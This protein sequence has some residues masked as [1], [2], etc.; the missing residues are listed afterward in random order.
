MNILTRQISIK[1]DNNDV[2]FIGYLRDGELSGDWYASAVG[3]VGGFQA[4]KTQVPPIPSGY[5]LIG[6]VTGHYKGKLTNTNPGSNLPER[7][8]VSLVTTQETTT[9]PPE[10]KISGNMR[11]YLGEFGS[12]EYVETKFTSVQFNFYSRYL[13]AKT[14]EY[15]ITL[16][17]ELSLD[18]VFTGDVFADGLGKVGTIELEDVL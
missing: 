11:F 13:T 5:A 8:T 1:S 10:M 15:G 12:T 16:K 7:V 3:K 14:E 2:S 6:T 17:G 4:M 9:T 18:G